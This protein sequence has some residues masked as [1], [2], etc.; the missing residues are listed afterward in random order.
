MVGDS[1]TDSLSDSRTVTVLIPKL[2]PVL[3]VAG[4][5][6]HKEGFACIWFS[7]LRC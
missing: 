7:V 4:S 6:A 5:A 3:V 2:I 1:C